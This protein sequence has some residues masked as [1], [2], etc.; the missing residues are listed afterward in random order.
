MKETKEILRFTKD[1]KDSNDIYLQYLTERTEKSDKHI[2]TSILYADF[3]RWFVENNQKTR[4]PSNRVFV[5]NLRNH[6]ILEQVR[7]DNKNTLG[8]KFLQ[9]INN[10]GDD[11]IEFVEV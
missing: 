11:N 7:V 4:I 1:Y 8:I 2:H 5:S 6:V 3:K 10:Y 9:L